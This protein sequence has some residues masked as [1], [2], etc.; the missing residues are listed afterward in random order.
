MSPRVI[1]ETWSGVGI[2]VARDLPGITGADG[3]PITLGLVLVVPDP[4]EHLTITIPLDENSRRELVRGLSGGI[5][6][7]SPEKIV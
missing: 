5:V 4:T 3:E 7:A 6:L 2:G 1:Q